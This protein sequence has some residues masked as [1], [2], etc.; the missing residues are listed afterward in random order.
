MTRFR[1]SLGPLVVDRISTSNALARIDGLIRHGRGGFVVNPSANQLALA[2]RLPRLRAA[3]NNASLSLASGRLLQ[4]ASWA[5]RRPLPERFSG[6]DFLFALAEHAERR[7]Y[8]VFLVGA[9]EQVAAKVSERLTEQFPGL[10]IVGQ[11]SSVWPTSHPRQ[12][13]R[14]IRASGAQ[15]VILGFASPNQE[16]WMLQHAEDI[17]PAVAFGLGSALEVVAQEARLT[18]RWMSRA[19]IGWSYELA[20]EPCRAALQ[21]V[22]GGRRLLPSLVRLFS[23]RLRGPKRRTAAVAA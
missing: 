16:A 19:G 22:T 1:L 13:L 20:C 3:Y 5:L 9:S 10:R 4:L 14:K 21:H 23:A 6:P 11:D 15:L 18:P 12:L 8:G 17:Q 2:E 7:D